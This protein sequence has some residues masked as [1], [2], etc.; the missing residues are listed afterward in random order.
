MKRKLLL[1]LGILLAILISFAQTPIKEL[2]EFAQDLATANMHLRGN[3]ML[4]GRYKNNLST[5]NYKS[6]LNLLKKT[7]TISNKGIT[8]EIQKS[9]KRYF[10][11]NDTTFYL[12]LYIK[13]YNAVIYDNA[14]KSTIDSIKLLKPN[15][16]IPD[17][18]TF[19][20]KINSLKK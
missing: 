12:V 18:S 7:E 6:Y 20:R 10:A 4:Y 9:V 19:P 14:Y 1:S 17:L 15:E 2:Q 5:L 11:S 3:L 8:T 16:S 13:K